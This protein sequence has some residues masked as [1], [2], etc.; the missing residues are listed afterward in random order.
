MKSAPT[1]LLQLSLLLFPAI[2]FAQSKIEATQIKGDFNGDGKIETATL[3]KPKINA[4][5]LSC[6]GPCVIKI[7]FSGNNV[8]P[9]T[10]VNSIGAVMLT[11]LGDLNNDGKDEIGYLPDWFTSCWRMYHVFT[12]NQNTWKELVTGFPTY[13]TQVEQKEP[14]FVEKV[15]GKPAY[16]RIYYSDMNLEKGDFPVK[17]KLVKMATFR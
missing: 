2:A 7:V 3:V 1:L 16:L 13:C 17:S 6:N 8:Q 15:P 9:I 14:K 4:D 12:Y 11:N 5:G 10:Q